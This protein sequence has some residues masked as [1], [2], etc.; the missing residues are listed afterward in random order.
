MGSYLVAG[1]VLLVA[2]AAAQHPQTVKAQQ[3]ASGTVALFKVGRH[4]RV[5]GRAKAT[6]L[7]RKR[8]RKGERVRERE[9]KRKKDCASEGHGKSRAETASTAK[10]N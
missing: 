5:E 1:Y 7:E 10:V 3:Q 4:L 6:H 8:E 2:S 9:R